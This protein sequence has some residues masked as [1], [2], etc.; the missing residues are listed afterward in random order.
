MYV[1]GLGARM[2]YSQ[3][4]RYDV[5]MPQIQTAV[6]RAPSATMAIAASRLRQC[7]V[8]LAEGDPYR[9]SCIRCS[10]SASEKSGKY[11][12]RFWMNRQ[13]NKAC[14]HRSPHAPSRAGTHCRL[15]FVS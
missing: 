13:A 12:A 8:A 3:A 1:A 2:A 6:M 14:R 7:H 15:V 5:H 11:L 4:W 9:R 10:N